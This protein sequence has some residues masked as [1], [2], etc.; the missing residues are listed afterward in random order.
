MLITEQDLLTF[1]TCPRKY[2]FA[3]DDTKCKPLQ[4]VSD[5]QQFMAVWMWTYEIMHGIKC[6]DRAL[7]EKWANTVTKTHIKQATTDTGLTTT[8]ELIASGFPLIRELYD[9]YLDFDCK[10]AA[11]M[12]PTRYIVPHIGAIKTVAHVIGLNSLGNTIILNWS[13]DYNIHDTTTNLVHQI[14]LVAAHNRAEATQLINTRITKQ[15]PQSFIRIHELNCKQLDKNIK[16]ILLAMQSRIDYP[17]LNCR[18][19]CK[20]KNICY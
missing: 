16:H 14:R 15:L 12:L 13:T 3:K 19:S 4:S 10:P 8:G 17:I 6:S 2:S 9:R 5:L 18:L 7:K 20:H 1:Q 11:A